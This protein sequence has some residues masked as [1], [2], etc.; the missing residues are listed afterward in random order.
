[1]RC[2]VTDR[3]SFLAATSLLLGVLSAG[4]ASGS[5]EVRGSINGAGGASPVEVALVTAP[6][7]WELLSAV[8]DDDSAGL[9]PVEA[10]AQARNG[11]FSLQIDEPDVRW[12]RVRRSG[13]ATRAYLLVGPETDTM[14][15]DLTFEEGVSCILTLTEPRRAWIAAGRGLRGAGVSPF[16][17]P[18]PPLRRLDAGA[19]IRLDP[20]SGAALSVGAP[21]YEPTTVECGSDGRSVVQL[22]PVSAPIV[23]GVLH[24]NGSAVPD[25]IL[26]GEDGWPVARTDELGRYRAPAGV[27]EVLDRHGGMDAVE[28]VGGVAELGARAQRPVSVAMAEDEAGRGNPPAV[29]VSHWSSSDGLLA[30]GYERPDDGW[31]SIGSRPGVAGTTLSVKRFA[32]L[33]IAW[34]APPTELALAPLNRL[35]G[36]VRDVDG[37]PVES[38][39]VLVS[40]QGA[41][42][43]SVTDGAGRFVVEVGELLDRGWLVART[44]AFRSARERL[45]DLVGE[46][47]PEQIVVELEPFR[48]IVGRLA[49]A[50]TGRGVAGIVVLAQA[51]VIARFVGDAALWNLEDPSLLRVV[52]TNGDGSFGIEPVD[53]GDVRLLAASPGHGTLSM[54]LPEHA[55]NGGEELRLGDVVL[56]REVVLWGRVTDEDGSVVE[57]ATID[58]GPDTP[59]GF[60]SIPL[61][62]SGTVIEEL[63]ADSD[64]RFRI[65][66]LARGDDLALEVSA[67]GFVKASVS[68]GSVGASVAVEDV[69]VRLRRAGELTGTVT[70]ELTG[71]GVEGARVHLAQTVRGGG[72][73]GTSDDAGQF[74]LGGFPLGA[75]ILTVRAR[76]YESLERFLAEAPRDPLELALRPEPEI[77]VV[78]VMVRDGAPV[79]GASVSIGSAV[80]VTDFAGRFHLT[81]PPGRTTLACRV[82][83]AR[84]PCLRELDVAVDMAE[85]TVDITPVTVRGRV[86]GSDGMPVEAASVRVWGR[87]NLAPRGPDRVTVGRGGEF[88]LRVEPGRYGVSAHRGDAQG[89]ELELAV[90]AGDEPHVDLTVP[91][92]DLVRVRVLGLT[93]AEA[94]EVLVS[95]RALYE[96]GGMAGRG[97]VRATGGTAAEPVFETPFQRRENATI[98]ATASA[99]GRVRRVPVEYAADGVTEV[100]ISFADGKGVVEGTLM[101]DGWPLPGEKVYVADRQRGLTWDVRTDHAGAFVIDGLRPGDEIVLAALGQERSIRVTDTTAQVHLEANSASV[102]GRLF[103]AET[104][105]PA[106]GMGVSA[107]PMQVA[108]P[109][110]V[111][112]PSRRRPSTRTAWDGSFVIDGLFAVPYRLE[113]RPAGRNLSTEPVVGSS[114]VDLSTGDLEVT[115]AVPL[116]EKR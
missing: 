71:A 8:L 76:G 43:F 14:L 19:A 46:F 34:S 87:E 53:E 39:E 50:S 67:A 45:S 26:V 25:S 44:P 49:S 37:G 54:K 60:F 55:T 11:R 69:E 4:G 28:A 95:I 41:G 64:G 59:P 100:E 66:G 77:D 23:E 92:P 90:V 16:W 86:T 115:V 80:S 98:V 116:P 106:A 17:R 27:Y 35:T 85:L 2:R 33:R 114:E 6:S 83:G 63:T 48:A 111:V 97:L 38:A 110:E 107:V 68:V 30:R 65:G 79:T 36:V 15:P 108:D 42:P 81:S 5:V 70:D 57:G 31:L 75:G 104:G 47:G 62:A 12:V 9:Y 10:T 52:R 88:E 40:S 72:A 61:S 3:V 58:F 32:P 13:A 96:N 73:W 51:P 24:R 21:G 102:R 113:I 93:P 20:G 18:W 82:P 78:G 91:D 99:A 56:E 109:G 7:L 29:L 1:M 112:W 89:P 103:D 84:R 101:L 74:A 22:E 105:Q 94:A